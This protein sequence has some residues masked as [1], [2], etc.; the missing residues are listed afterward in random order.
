MRKPQLPA[1]LRPVLPPLD[2]VHARARQELETNTTVTVYRF[3]NGA[4]IRWPANIFST[5]SALLDSITAIFQPFIGAIAEVASQFAEW[6][7]NLAELAELET[8][9][10]EPS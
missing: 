7:P 2:D 9:E 1:I 4:E 5:I 3:V 8:I 6:L 10:G